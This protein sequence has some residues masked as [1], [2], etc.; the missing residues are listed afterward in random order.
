MQDK[1]DR[2]VRGMHFLF[3]KPEDSKCQTQA[4]VFPMSRPFQRQLKTPRSFFRNLPCRS[5]FPLMFATRVFAWPSTDSKASG[6][7]SHFCCLLFDHLCVQ[8]LLDLVAET[9]DVRG[10]PQ[11]IHSNQCRNKVH[12]PQEHRIKDVRSGSNKANPWHPLHQNQNHKI[13]GE[14]TS[15]REEKGFNAIH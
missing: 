5:P 15:S 8:I 4:K 2:C 6:P 3:A 10:L 14:R 12:I 1:Y 7:E 9:R 11:I 13:M